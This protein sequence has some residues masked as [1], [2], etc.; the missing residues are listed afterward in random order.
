MK[1]TT[2]R[3]LVTAALVTTAVPALAEKPVPAAHD[4]VT[5]GAGGTAATWGGPG[6]HADYVAQPATAPSTGAERVDRG[7]ALGGADVHSDYRVD[8]VAVPP[9]PP[10]PEDVLAWGGRGMHSDM[11]AIP[12]RPA[13]PPNHADAHGVATA[14]STGAPARAPATT[15]Q[16]EAD[17]G[18]GSAD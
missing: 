18:S 9:G 14:R 7:S 13:V 8:A 17:T 10:A 2:L 4:D 1:I 11:P 15:A 6:M 12:W 16:V 5:D 3:F